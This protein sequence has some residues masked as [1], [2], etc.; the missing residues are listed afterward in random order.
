MQHK[1][2]PRLLP[3]QKGSFFLF[4]PRGCGKSTWLAHT[5][6]TA[7]VVDL[8]DE[9]RYQS[10]LADPSLFF[11][12]LAGL[13]AGSWVAVDEIQRLPQ[14]LNEVHRLI[15]RRRLKFALTG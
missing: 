1:V 6:P 11:E 14:L 2:F 13:H 12:A 9:A 3:A 15:E 7:T 5:Y 4:G 10:Y 8:L